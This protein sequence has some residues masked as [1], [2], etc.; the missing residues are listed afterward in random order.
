MADDNYP[1]EEE[2]QEE[3]EIDETVSNSG[4]IVWQLTA[5]LSLT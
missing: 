5:P 2:I 1:R 4:A 3:E